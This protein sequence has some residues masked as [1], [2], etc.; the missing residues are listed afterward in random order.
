MLGSS[1]T[2]NYH[3]TF[4][5]IEIGGTILQDVRIANKLSDYLSR[6]LKMDGPTTIWLNKKKYI[7]GVQLP[8]GARYA[9]KPGG[10]V[11]MAVLATLLI[12]FFGAGLIIWLFILLGYPEYRRQQQFIKG[13]PNTV[14]L[15]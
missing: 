4:T 15:T 13:H 1:T 6:G 3:T 12:P 7:I 9:A 5:T 11:F 8:D 2:D 10:F 14:V